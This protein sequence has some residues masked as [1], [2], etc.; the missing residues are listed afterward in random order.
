MGVSFS[1]CRRESGEGRR[2]RVFSQVLTTYRH[3]A[4][5]DHLGH[6][7]QGA[8]HQSDVDSAWNY[9]V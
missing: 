9:V 1:F 4:A 7:A 8:G 6:K 5:D 3:L 2:E